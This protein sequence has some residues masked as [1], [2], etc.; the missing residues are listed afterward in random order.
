MPFIHIKSLPFKQHIEV[1]EVVELLNRKFASELDISLEHVTV[2]WEFFLPGH[3]AHSGK[4]LPRQAANSHP[5][6]VELFTPDF[7][8]DETITKM[9]ECIADFLSENTGV[10]YENIFISHR[11]VRSGRVFNGGKIDK[12]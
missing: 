5:L 11:E 2:T 6:Q 7:F 12:W 9:F 8:T 3:Y 1:E 10:K 4:V